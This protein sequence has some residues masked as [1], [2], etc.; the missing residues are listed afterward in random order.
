MRPHNP[1]LRLVLEKG[2]QVDQAIGGCTSEWS[3]RR[4][5]CCQDQSSLILEL[6]VELILSLI[7]SMARFLCE[8]SQPEATVG[9]IKSAYDFIPIPSKAQKMVV[10]GTPHGVKCT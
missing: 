10:S 6:A 2:Y 5:T 8:E 3:N 4:R 7:T 9:V 1:S